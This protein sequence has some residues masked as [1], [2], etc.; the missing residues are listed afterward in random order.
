M[1]P[2]VATASAVVLTTAASRAAARGV[3]GALPGRLP[4]R[5]SDSR[6]DSA[7]PPPRRLGRPCGRLTCSRSAAS[8]SDSVTEPTRRLV[9]TTLRT[10]SSAGRTAFGPVLP[11]AAHTQWSVLERVTLGKISSDGSQLALPT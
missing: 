9:R 1:D 4:C 11:C 3:D 6:G 7:P 8:S 5:D 10:Q 2:T